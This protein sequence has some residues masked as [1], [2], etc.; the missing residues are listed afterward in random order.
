MHLCI[1]LWHYV[2]EDIIYAVYSDCV[3][4]FAFAFLSCKKKKKKENVL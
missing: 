2:R 4:V 3:L 1:A